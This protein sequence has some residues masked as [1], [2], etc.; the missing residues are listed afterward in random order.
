MIKIEPTVELIMNTL[1]NETVV[2]PTS[3]LGSRMGK[4]TKQLNKAL[5]P[6]L[7]KPVLSHIIDQFPK[8]TSFI[9]PVGYLSK[10]VIDYCNA[11]H[12]DLDIAF[13]HVDDYTSELSGTGYT[14]QQ[15][16]H[17]LNKP[18]WYIPCDTYY[19]IDLLEERKDRN[20][21]FT[22]HVNKE[23][24][25][26]YTM[27]SRNAKNLITDIL[28]KK[29]TTDD[30][31]AF[32]GVIYVHDYQDFNT[33]LQNMDSNE[34]IHAIQ[35]NELT[36]DLDSWIDFGSIESYQTAL[37]NSQKFDFSKQDEI[38]YVTDTKV[39]KWWLDPTVTENK[40]QRLLHNKTIYP[41]NCVIHGNYLAY[42]FY[43]G[44]TLYQ[45]NNIDCLP[46][47]LSWLNEQVWHRHDTD[48]THDCMDFYK[49]KT[50]G[51]IEKYL[52]KHDFTETVTE[53]NGVKI[54]DY[55]YYLNKIDYSYLTSVTQPA[56][57]HGDLQFDN[58][59]I[60]PDKQFKLIDWRPDFAGNTM[61]GDIYYDLAKMAGGFIIDYS[62]IK[63]NDF[64]ITIDNGIATLTI[65][66]IDNHAEYFQVLKDFV[67]SQNLDWRKV[68]TLIPII[69]WNMA[70]LHTKPFDKFLW[71]LGMKLFQELEE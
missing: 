71:Y 65:P 54:K 28:F 56:Y 4:L 29:E 43:P 67:T 61:T 32:T 69:F 27:F 47:L 20:C 70:P 18:Y 3:G 19:N 8:N 58:I 60:G 14:I 6:Y 10:Q 17:L 66:Y 34:I 1:A 31:V 50:Q 45:Y 16:L 39:V 22:K 51:R 25:S 36:V 55:Q 11:A 35:L 44:K 68:E 12:P 38:T 53:V 52:A 57:I 7:G 24:S 41:N 40:Y 64:T 21:Y 42:D 9:I 62:K 63:E 59:I 2:I 37:S 48:I 26:L 5:L 49:Q 23:L 46:M 13:V 33:R 30:Y 15:C